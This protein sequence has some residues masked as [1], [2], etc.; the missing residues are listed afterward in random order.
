MQKPNLTE[1]G[2][3]SLGFDATVTQIKPWYT[4][5]KM[6]FR[7]CGCRVGFMI[8]GLGFSVLVSEFISTKTCALSVL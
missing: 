5:R 8:L 1:L 3:S 7:V 6:A 2:T 4:T